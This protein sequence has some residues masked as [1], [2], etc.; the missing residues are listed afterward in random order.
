MLRSKLFRFPCP[1][2]QFRVCKTLYPKGDAVFSGI[3]DYVDSV[4]EPLSN[5]GLIFP[6][7]LFT[8][9]ELRY[10]CTVKILV[11][12]ASVG[13]PSPLVFIFLKLQVFLA[14]PTEPSPS[15]ARSPRSSS[16]SGFP[17]PAFFA[18]AAPLSR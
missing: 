15:P 10:M 12:L 8:C 2:A 6:Y 7:W 4:T 11:Q 13:V 16:W 1:V 14:K 5:C 3:W 17:F 18:C 9:P